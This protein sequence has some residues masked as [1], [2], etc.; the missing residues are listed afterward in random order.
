M[1]PPARIC[2]IPSR[3]TR[4]GS[5]T[6]RINRSA[7]IATGAVPL[8]M[9]LLLTAY[10]AAT[11]WP[12]VVIVEQ[13]SVAT[14][15]GSI[16]RNPVSS[17]WMSL[18]TGFAWPSSSFGSIRRAVGFLGMPPLGPTLRRSGQT[19]CLWQLSSHRTKAEMRAAHVRRWPRQSSGPLMHP[20]TAQSLPCIP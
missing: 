2:P 3:K 13:K 5:W 17:P 11:L 7:L 6:A 15:R 20:A 12:K 8:I 16:I 19:R 18:P 1:P 9:L 14:S 4:Q 10:L